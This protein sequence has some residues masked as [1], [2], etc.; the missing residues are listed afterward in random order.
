MENG[1]QILLV[2]DDPDDAEMAIYAL[3]KNNLVSNLI[4]IDDGAKALEYL[5]DDAIPLPAAILLD[6][7]MPRVDGIEILRILKN[8]AVRKQI[9]VI[10]L[11]SS[12]EGR[13]YLESYKLKADAYLTK[14]INSQ[15]FLTALA[16]VGVSYTH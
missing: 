14:P 1:K 12:K 16:E 11:I 4:H 10:A 13:S 5:L 7:K 15:N 6:L 2:E 3:K 8:D 9:P